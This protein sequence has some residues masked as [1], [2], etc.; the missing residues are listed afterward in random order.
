MQPKRGFTLIELLVV[1]A[2]IGILATIIVPNILDATAKARNAGRM[3]SL[4]NLETAL[5]QYRED[6]AQFPP[7]RNGLWYATFDIFPI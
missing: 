3:A 4:N 7:T 6:N 1:I 5:I 2:I